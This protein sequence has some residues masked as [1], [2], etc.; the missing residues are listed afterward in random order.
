MLNKL[1]KLLIACA[2][3]AGAFAW[4]PAST[5]QAAFKS[6]LD[7]GLEAVIRDALALPDS[8]EVTEDEVAILTSLFITEG[9][10]MKSLRGLDE[11]VFLE[12]VFLLGAHADLDITALADVSSLKFLAIDEEALNEEGQYVVNELKKN[13]VEIL[14]LED[15]DEDSSY[16]PSTIHVFVDGE[17]IEFPKDPVIINGST[18]VPFRKL[19]E[20]FGLEV[21]WDPATRTAT[22]TKEKLE[23]SLT[24]DSNIAIV[25]GQEI[26]LP[27]A[28]K[29]VDGNTMVPLRF[30]GE[31]TGRRVTW[32]GVMRFVH[33]DT[34]I[35]SYN[36]EYL[37]SND[38]EYFGDKKDGK[39]HGEGRLLHNGSLFYE[40]EFK[41]GVIEG[42]GIMYDLEDRSSYYEGEFKNNRY[43]GE[44][45]IV[46]SDGTYYVGP[47]ADGMREGTGKL[48]NADGSLLYTG[49]F[50][51]DAIHG[52]GTYYFSETDYYIGNFERGLFE[53][54]GKIYADGKL[55]YDGLFSADSKYRGKNYQGGKLNYEGYFHDDNPHGYGTLYTTS[56][57]KYYRGQFQYGH[58]T[59]VGIYYME[60]GSRNIGE[61][62]Y[63]T[64]DGFGFIKY[65]DHTFS[66][67][68]Y[69]VNDEYYGEE[70]PPVTEAATLKLLTRNAGYGYIDGYF[71]NQFDLSSVEA[72]MII[73]LA[74]EEHLELF[75]DLNKEAKA[76]F[77]NDF[78]QR[79]WGDVVGV[80]DVY[81]FVIY[82][83]DVYAKATIQYEMENSAVQVT[84]Y[85][86]GNGDLE[87]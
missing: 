74:S 81:A 20:E 10:S 54:Q 68:G 21:G 2:I 30:I 1:S 35:T 76:A 72:M 49:A 11:A 12:E 51:G 59:G 66:N 9:E 31:A 87:K 36:F 38:T 48:L 14:N 60:D 79:N 6:D 58:I 13:D 71:I 29:I 32:D 40:G 56:G 7:Q 44:G 69:W 18:M 46:Y 73:E 42:K 61:V 27:T 15:S 47:F 33:I 75:N 25:S 85:P 67:V 41:N 65:D 82:D 34:T 86:K 22:G 28:P 24:I 16:T 53:G 83:G 62:Y 45:K 5:T 70:E 55:Q 84:E 52:K 39:P 77:M 78:V 4:G 63:D 19:F 3:T 26:A 8:E 57:N 80:D 50:S 37:Y 64:M 43:Q 23:I 17:I